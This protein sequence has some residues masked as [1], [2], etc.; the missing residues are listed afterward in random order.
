MSKISS[1][2]HG[3][4]LLGNGHCFRPEDPNEDFKTQILPSVFLEDDDIMEI[5]YRKDSAILNQIVEA[6][7]GR[8]NIRETW[9]SHGKYLNEKGKQIKSTKLIKGKDRSNLFIKIREFFS[10]NKGVT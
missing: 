2:K 4:F 10:L 8:F 3:L 1:D 6:E 5:V 7:N 9:H